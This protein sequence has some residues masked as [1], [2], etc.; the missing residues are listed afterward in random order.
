M[1]TSRR[2]DESDF[3]YDEFVQLV[4]KFKNVIGIESLHID[5]NSVCDS[6]C[7]PNPNPNLTLADSTIY[8]IS[9]LAFQRFDPN[10]Y[11][12]IYVH[13]FSIICKTNNLKS[14]YLS[15]NSNRS[16]CISAVNTSSRIAKQLSSNNYTS[17]YL[18]V[19][20]EKNVYLLADYKY[21][22][23][24]L[25]PI[26]YRNVC[27]FIDELK[28]TLASYTIYVV[29][30]QDSSVQ[31]PEREISPE[32]FILWHIFGI[33]CLYK[34]HPHESTFVSVPIADC[35]FRLKG[36]KNTYELVPVKKPSKTN[37]MS[38]TE[39]MARENTGSLLFP[40]DTQSK[41]KIKMLADKL[42]KTKA[43]NQ[44]PT[45]IEP[46]DNSHAYTY[47]N[48]DILELPSK[49]GKFTSTAPTEPD[50]TDETT[51]Y[52]TR[53][54]R[55]TP[56]Y[57]FNE[58]EMPNYKIGYPDNI[59]YSHSHEPMS[60]PNSQIVPRQ[61]LNV[62]SNIYYH[63]FKIYVT[64]DQDGMLKKAIEPKIIYITYNLH[65]TYNADQYDAAVSDLKRQMSNMSTCL[66]RNVLF[67]DNSNNALLM[68][69]LNQNFVECIQLILNGQIDTAPIKRILRN[70][71]SSINDID[72]EISVTY[73]AVLGDIDMIR[74]YILFYILI[75]NI[76]NSCNSN[77]TCHTSS[78]CAL[79]HK[80]QMENSPEYRMLFDSVL[81]IK[82]KIDK[83]ISADNKLVGF[84]ACL[85]PVH[86]IKI[87]TKF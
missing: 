54:H 4:Y 83:K 57:N 68:E 47:P 60:I 37:E 52:N 11:P 56:S 1:S 46:H 30:V 58:K 10:L 87:A 61:Q 43:N 33:M 3:D 63:P 13:L 12:D 31:F 49:E 75:S 82:F 24:I 70:Y 67:T 18:Y 51:V 7:N 34:P 48:Q 74:L 19:N 45:K 53:V 86:L 26:N 38:S 76:L 64:L 6:E 9:F 25:T 73:N 44:K 32:M 17:N 71:P 66:Y 5:P 62:P 84:V 65:G 59:H 2:E 36:C 22:I 85:P 41:G 8:P 15:S 23:Y 80:K 39:I 20:K 81:Q 21:P 50:S 72:R 69:L 40:R 14:E 55:V 16:E 77:R 35:M 29:P 28:T 79:F 27:N 42:H 78:N